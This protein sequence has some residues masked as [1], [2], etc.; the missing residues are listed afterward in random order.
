MED[1]RSRDP[2]R[3]CEQQCN[4]DLGR[5]VLLADLLGSDG[6]HPASYLVVSLTPQ[7]AQ[8]FDDDLEP[9]QR[10]AV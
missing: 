4:H 8:L 3:S 10:E 6:P 5:G 9:L 1:D 7:P 2:Y